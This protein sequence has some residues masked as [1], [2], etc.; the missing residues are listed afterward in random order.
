MK[1]TCRAGFS[2]FIRVQVQPVR[3]RPLLL[4]Q[5]RRQAFSR[6]AVKSQS[7]GLARCSLARLAARA[8]FQQ[9][10]WPGSDAGQRAGSAGLVAAAGWPGLADDGCALHAHGCRSARALR[11]F[12]LRAGLAVARRRA[13]AHLG[14]P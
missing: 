2:W 9:A 14:A 1:V 3:K 11:A 4:D 8:L 10:L 5:I 12:S 7:A 13:G 6:Q